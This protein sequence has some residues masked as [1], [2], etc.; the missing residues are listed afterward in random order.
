VKT[1]LTPTSL[2][3]SNGSALTADDIKAKKL[4]V[5]SRILAGIP[6]QE[7]GRLLRYWDQVS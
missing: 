2:P 4:L 5:A 3:L 1:A 6:L 7:L